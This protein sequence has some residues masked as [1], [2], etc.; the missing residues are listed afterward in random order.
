MNPTGRKDTDLSPF[1]SPIGF[2]DVLLRS[3]QRFRSQEYLRSTEAWQEEPG[4]DF[5]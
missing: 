2:T 5:E 1:R 3:D 4:D